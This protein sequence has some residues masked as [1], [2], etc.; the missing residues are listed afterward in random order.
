MGPILSAIC[1]AHKLRIGLNVYTGDGGDHIKTST[2]I[3]SFI[4][5]QTCSFTHVFMVVFNTTMAEL[6]TYDKD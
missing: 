2:S 1:A 6:N 5:T 4:G 3:Y